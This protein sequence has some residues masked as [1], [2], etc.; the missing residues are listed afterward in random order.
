MVKKMNDRITLR[1]AMDIPVWMAVYAAEPTR[2]IDV[3]MN[4]ADLFAVYQWFHTYNPK[5]DEE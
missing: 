5:E 4:Y 3:E 2:K 1:N